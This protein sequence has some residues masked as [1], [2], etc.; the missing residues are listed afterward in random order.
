MSWNVIFRV[1]IGQ[2]MNQTVFTGFENNVSQ[3]AQ[4]QRDQQL[5]KLLRRAVGKRHEPVVGDEADIGAKHVEEVYGAGA[6]QGETQAHRNEGQ[7]PSR[8]YHALEEIRYRLPGFAGAHEMG[9]PDTGACSIAI[10]LNAH[11]FTFV[12]FTRAADLRLLRAY[13]AYRERGGN[14]VGLAIERFVI[15]D[16]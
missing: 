13:P 9:S 1:N 5:H 15:D 10:I 11:E 3:H 12:E 14:W 2:E 7:P 8:E 16:S 6:K 4:H